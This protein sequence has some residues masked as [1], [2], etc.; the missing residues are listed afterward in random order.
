MSHLQVAAMHNRKGVLQGAALLEKV[1]GT[2]PLQPKETVRKRM[3]VLSGAAMSV[4]SFVTTIFTDEM[5]TTFLNLSK[6]HHVF[7][8]DFYLIA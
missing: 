7:C 8:Y 6:S 2:Q 3:A 4:V 1:W 5:S